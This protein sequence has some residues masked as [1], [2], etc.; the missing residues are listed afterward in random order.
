M[1]DH[2]EE[3]RLGVV[4]ALGFFARVAQGALGLDPVGDIA[5]D[6]LHFGTR[7]CAGAHDDL[8]PGDPA[9]APLGCDFLIVDA[10]A[11][12]EHR[13]F[14]LLG[15]RQREVAAEERRALARSESAKGVVGEGDAA[16]AVAAHNHVALRLDKTSRAML[17]LL[18]L[19]VAVGQIL[20]PRGR[21]T[22]FRLE[23]TRARE[24]EAGCSARR[25]EQR[26]R[27]DRE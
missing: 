19:P 3:A 22:Q 23:V 5:A 1:R 11:V 26:R 7:S 25:A 9:R 18:E 15:G 10:R 6:A 2:G 13:G 14:A 21:C 20:D 27:P 12:R 4:R 16:L 8:A 17:G 24:Q